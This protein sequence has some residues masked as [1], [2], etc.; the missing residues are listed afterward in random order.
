[1]HS[2]LSQSDSI[3][4][5]KYLVV[6][7]CSTFDLYSNHDTSPY[8]YQSNHY[9]K[10]V[11]K[12]FY[13]PNLSF[14]YFLK[15]KK[16]YRFQTG[17]EYTFA[18]YYIAQTA[19]PDKYNIG[20]F[21]NLK[22]K[23]HIISIPFYGNVALLKNRLLVGLGISADAIP[24]ST[25]SGN[26]DLYYTTATSSTYTP[27]KITNKR[28]YISPFDI[29]TALKFSYLQKVKKTWVIIEAKYKHGLLNITPSRY[30]SGAYLHNDIMTL[31]GGI[32]F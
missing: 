4:N 25:I 16:P 13:G 17:I 10:S 11:P 31:S 23:L 1:M 27:E 26:K 32:C 8:S 14:A 7:A 30:L 3:Y 9:D 20:T 21:S 29:S 6:G 28:G 24:Y 12:V 22:L 18:Q 19:S 15:S 5:R 2:G